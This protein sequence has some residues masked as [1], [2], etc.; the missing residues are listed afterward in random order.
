MRKCKCR[1]GGIGRKKAYSRKK[2]NKKIVATCSDLYGSLR[3]GK[4]SG[5]YFV[6]KVSDNRVQE[7]KNFTDEFEATRFFKSICKKH[8]LDIRSTK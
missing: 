8:D 5:R 4:M 7:R 1:L 2:I 3:L 6:E